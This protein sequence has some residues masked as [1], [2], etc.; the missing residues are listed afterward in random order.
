MCNFLVPW[1]TNIL[2]I[3]SVYMSI[4]YRVLFQ[5]NDWRFS[6]ISE[7]K[8]IIQTMK[9]PYNNTSHVITLFSVTSNVHFIRKLNRL[10]KLY[11]FCWSSCKQILM[12]LV[13]W[14][15]DPVNKK[16]KTVMHFVPIQSRLPVNQSCNGERNVI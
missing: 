14:I 6:N 7:A 12:I 13:G 16:R 8:E 1:E 9:L 4:F 2:D 11:C 3:L 5:N 10:K 15:T